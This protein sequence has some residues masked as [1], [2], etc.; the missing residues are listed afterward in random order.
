LRKGGE[1]RNHGEE[2]ETENEDKC[3][4]VTRFP[5]KEPVHIS[6]WEILS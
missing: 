3:V 2:K 5:E 4:I 6:N 1:N